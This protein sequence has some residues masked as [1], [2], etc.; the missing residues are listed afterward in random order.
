LDIV[1]KKMIVFN[2]AV[3]PD[4]HESVLIFFGWIRIRIK[5]DTNYPQKGKKRRQISLRPVDPDPD[6]GG[7]K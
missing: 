1:K 4:P 3:D 7:Q 5:E 2:S 6:S